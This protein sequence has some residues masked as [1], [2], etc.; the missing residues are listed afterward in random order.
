MLQLAIFEL[1]ALYFAVLSH[2][3]ATV[4]GAEVGILANFLINDRISFSHR[5]HKLSLGRRLLRHQAVVVVAVFLQWLIVFMTER[6]TTDF[7]LLHLALFAG[8]ALGFVWNYAW[9]H[10]FVW[11]NHP[12]SEI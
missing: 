2:S 4:V 12:A 5:Q 7:W 10:L 3:A 9:Y 11:R 6:V 8:I 1:L